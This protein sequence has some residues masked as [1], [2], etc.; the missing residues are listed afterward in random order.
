M[1]HDNRPIIA[2]AVS[3]P[4]GRLVAPVVFALACVVG[5]AAALF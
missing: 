3:T 5:A 4:A 2:D 1:P